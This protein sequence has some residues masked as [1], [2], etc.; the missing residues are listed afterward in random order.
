MEERSLRE[1]IIERDN[2]S[3]FGGYKDMSGLLK[4]NL[5]SF[6]LC[7][8]NNTFFVKSA[9]EGN[10]QRQYVRSGHMRVFT[11]DS[12]SLISRDGF[13]YGKFDCEEY[14]W[15]EQI[16]ESDY[17][18]CRKN[19]KYGII[20]GN[21][22]VVLDVVYPLITRLPKIVD[23]D[24]VYWCESPDVRDIRKE[25][26]DENTK[27]YIS[28]KITTYIGEYLLELTTLKKSKL[29]NKIYTFGKNYLVVKNGHYGLVSPLGEEIVPPK[30]NK[31]YPIDDDTITQRCIPEQYWYCGDECNAFIEIE[32]EGHLVPIANNGKY[33]GEIPLEYDECY[34]VDEN[35]YF[36]RKR[37]KCGLLNYN[38][39][40][41]KIS[42]TIPTDYISISFD[43]HHPFYH[44][45]NK[46]GTCINF[47]IVQD[48]KGYQ[49]YNITSKTLV[50]EHYQSLKYTYNRGSHTDYRNNGRYAPFFIAQKENKYA[51]LSQFGM[52]LTD[53]IYESISPM[54]SNIFPVCKDDKWGI[55]DEWGRTLVECE[56]D[57]FERVL[58]GKA[59]L[60][61]GNETITKEL[62][63]GRKIKGGRRTSTYERPTYER[64]GGSYAQDEMGYSDDDI[65]TIFDGDP[66]AY[67]N[68]D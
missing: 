68:I 47:A 45:W 29:Y 16:Y 57:G 25:E 23:I 30:Y 53:F 9:E 2:S 33:Y 49:L 40:S 32:C 26:L 41:K 7:S 65:D 15:V 59:W 19:E 14:D 1:I 50:G 31:A 51:I 17:Y 22:N 27:P 55:I 18:I 56:W 20:E 44:F 54:N 43:E 35:K 4:E 28:L 5:C 58:G 52:P 63:C 39:I 64:Y 8:D 61:Q 48:E 46:K 12:S 10:R 11:Y 21:S 37:G 36:V 6:S 3:E 24:D 60:I 34:R 42:V 62:N 66:L 67:W 38:A 13:F